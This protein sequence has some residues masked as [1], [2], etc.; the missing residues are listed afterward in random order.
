MPVLT[1]EQYYCFSLPRFTYDVLDELKDKTLAIDF[2][3][4]LPERS[5]G[6][7]FFEDSSACYIFFEKRA[8]FEE[9]FMSPEKAMDI[10]TEH[11]TEWREYDSDGV[12]SWLRKVNHA[13]R[14]S[15][16]TPED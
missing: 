9:G 12:N 1:S 11:M 15:E 2:V 16:T 8:D 6:F 14:S 5:G 10:Y 3:L 7:V 13:L 4:L